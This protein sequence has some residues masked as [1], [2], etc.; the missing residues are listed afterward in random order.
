MRSPSPASDS[1][2]RHSTLIPA[3]LLDLEPPRS[4]EDEKIEHCEPSR[5]CVTR[6]AVEGEHS[7]EDIGTSRCLK[8]ERFILRKTNSE[9]NLAEQ[10]PIKKP[11][12]IRPG[13]YPETYQFDDRQTLNTNASLSSINPQCSEDFPRA[14]T[15]TYIAMT[16]G[17]IDPT[18]RKVEYFENWKQS[19]ATR[20]KGDDNI[21]G[22]VYNQHN[23]I[24][25][26]RATEHKNTVDL[27]RRVS[28]NEDENSQRHPHCQSVAPQVP[29]RPKLQ[30][31]FSTLDVVGDRDNI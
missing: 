23:E 7:M 9:E 21:K 3:S 26:Y 20:C 19:T 2:V 18:N 6:E 16:A 31:R 27:T 10:G 15:E 11:R 25:S 17:E 24:Q 4:F 30:H 8:G 12:E 22:S 13:S 5:D 28:E 29:R 1:K 14:E